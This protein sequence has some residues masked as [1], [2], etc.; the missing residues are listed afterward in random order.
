MNTLTCYIVDDE[1][2]AIDLLKRFVAE[3]NGLE[4]AGAS[5]DPVL[6]LDEIVTAS[7]P[8]ITFLDVNMQQL[9]GI[10]VLARI[11]SY[12]SVI[13]TTAFPQYAVSA[14]DLQATDFLLKPF[15]Y[16]RF[17][18]AV[19]RVRRAGPK[20]QATEEKPPR[21]F[22]FIKTDTKGKLIRVMMTEILYVR[23]AQNYVEIFL[24]K[25]KHLTYLTLYEME[26]A[27]GASHFSRIHKS[28]I[29]NLDKIRSIEN[30]A[31][32]LCEGTL[33]PIGDNYREKFQKQLSEWSVISK[34]LSG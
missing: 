28:Y 11:C 5:D 24:D 17:L 25:G 21:D 3:T 8:D 22:F 33:V 34:R 7:P 1:F 13:L 30:G 12:T 14:F 32:I 23:S 18:Q 9:S 15:H 27:L 4:L 2:R 6:A 10:D 16:T 29:I 20:I 19:D 26:A 31:A